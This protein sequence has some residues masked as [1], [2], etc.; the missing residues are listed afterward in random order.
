MDDKVLDTFLSLAVEA[1]ADELQRAV[2][3]I[4]K[5]SNVHIPRVAVLSTGIRPG[6]VPMFISCSTRTYGPI[7]AVAVWEGD[8]E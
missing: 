7:L 1:G 3:S 8:W 2:E 5:C 4:Q 6:G